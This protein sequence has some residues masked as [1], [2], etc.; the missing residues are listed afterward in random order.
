M[1]IT[2]EASRLGTIP[3]TEQ[4]PVELRPNDSP[5]DIQA[6]IDTVYRQVLGNEYLMQS[7]RLIELESFL[8]NG[9]LTVRDFVRAVA[10]SDLYKTKFLYPNFQTRFIEL[11]FK[12]LLGRAPYD[13]AE[14]SEHV[15]RY[16]QQGYEAEIDSYLDSVEYLENF[17]DYVV[18]YCRGFTTQTSQKTV[19]FVRM[20]QLSR[21]YASSDR[22]QMGNKKGC[23][24]TE[25]A[26]N[27][28]SPVRTPTFGQE[29]RGSTVGQQERL[30]R[31][32]VFQAASGRKP[33]I[34]RGIQEYLVTYEQ[35]N[36]TLQRLNKRGYRI[37]NITSA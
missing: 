15:N 10:K 32:R 13:E 17:G 11:N 30:Y 23:L 8:N 6:V 1:A 36:P 2:V 24:A 37:V 29:L 4:S 35:L 18:P 31:I 19:G 5:E 20:F 27:L 9:S 34:R 14:I 22:A 3:F 7:E 21:G 33:Q 28:A 12:H 16:M 26:C 25:L